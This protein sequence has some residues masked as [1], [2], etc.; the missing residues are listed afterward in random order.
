MYVSLPQ[1][2]PRHALVSPA[3]VATAPVPDGAAAVR[4]REQRIDAELAQSF[5]ASDP[6]SWVH[7][8]VSAQD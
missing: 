1:H 7:G 3:P 2:V 4:A 5:P 6:P 8:T